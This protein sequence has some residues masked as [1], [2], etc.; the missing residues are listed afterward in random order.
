VFRIADVRQWRL[1]NLASGGSGEDAAIFILGMSVGKQ[2]ALPEIS[3]SSPTASIC[4]G[5]EIKRRVRG[6]LRRLPERP[7]QRSRANLAVGIV[8][9]ETRHLVSSG[10]KSSTHSFERA[11]NVADLRARPIAVSCSAQHDVGTAHIADV[12][13]PSLRFK[14]ANVRS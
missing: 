13:S 5:I 11:E 7:H 10:A 2:R 1:R 6:R 8:R 3:T 4:H 14:I 9:L 12:Q